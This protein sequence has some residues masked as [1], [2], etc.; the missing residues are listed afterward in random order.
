MV[1]TSEPWQPWSITVVTVTA[2]GKKSNCSTDLDL[3][4]TEG[5]AISSVEYSSVPW[6][7]FAG[8]SPTATLCYGVFSPD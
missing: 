3:Q 7:C 5:D 1:F 2:L 8:F 4:G 6:Q